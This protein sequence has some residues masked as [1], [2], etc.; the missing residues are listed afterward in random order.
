M[1]AWIEFFIVCMIGVVLLSVAVI[2]CYFSSFKPERLLESLKSNAWLFKWF[3]IGK[4]HC[5]LTPAQKRFIAL[6]HKIFWGGFILGWALFTAQ[7]VQLWK[8]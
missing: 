2:W 3:I 8:V 4:Y 5:D 1:E 7:L 6:L